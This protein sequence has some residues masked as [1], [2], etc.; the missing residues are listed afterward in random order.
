MRMYA[1]APLAALLALPALAEGESPRC[2][3]SAQISEGLRSKYGEERLWQGVDAF[4][5][6]VVLYFSQKTGTWTIT[7]T[8]PGA[9]TCAVNAGQQGDYQPPAS[10]ALEKEF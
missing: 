6:L 1:A 5:R 8:I 9:L 4:G 2:A 3:T 10:A 7:T